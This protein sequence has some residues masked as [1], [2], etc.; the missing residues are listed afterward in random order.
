MMTELP[1]RPLITTYEAEGR[2]IPMGG[3]LSPAM[4]I[5]TT[6]WMEDEETWV[7]ALN[8]PKAGSFKTRLRIVDG[9]R[10]TG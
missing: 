9:A 6:A 3:P 8:G 7:V 2:G 4:T 5:G 10:L 1:S